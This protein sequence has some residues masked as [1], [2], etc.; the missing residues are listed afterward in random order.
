MLVLPH[1]P[2]R[3]LP[4]VK[5]GERVQIRQQAL[6]GIG[7]LYRILLPGGDGLTI[8]VESRSGNRSLAL[9]PRGVDEPTGQVSLSRDEADA[10]ATLLS[11]LNVVADSQSTEPAHG[12]QVQT[13][14]I[15]PTSPA[16]GRVIGEIDL[17]DPEGARIIAVI[18]DDTP[19]LLEDDAER[20][21]AIGDRLVLAGRPSALGELRTYL[22]G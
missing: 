12:V 16:V 20:Q 19:E 4:T 21:V 2:T 9:L 13:L 7:Q 17:P 22:V 15:G 1:R 8:T 5:D 11:G 6:P 3:G 18:R 14:T 10:V